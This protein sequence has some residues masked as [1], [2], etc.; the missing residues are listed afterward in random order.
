[1]SGMPPAPRLLV[2]DPRGRRQVRQDH[3]DPVTHT[4]AWAPAES[5]PVMNGARTYHTMTRLPDGRILVAGGWGTGLSAEIYMPATDAP[6]LFQP[7]AH[8]MIDRGRTERCRRRPGHVRAVR[9]GIE[10]LPGGRFAGGTAR[11]CRVHAAAGRRR[12]GPDFRWL[13]AKLRVVGDR[14][15]VRPGVRGA[16]AVAG[17]PA[18]RRRASVASGSSRDWPRKPRYR[19]YESAAPAS[20]SPSLTRPCW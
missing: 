7:I 14:G 19:L 5:T 8:G 10:H 2:T 13:R 16:G 11:R 6:G 4:G 20:F 12:Q 3:C 15:V 17:Y 9:S 1:M 18:A